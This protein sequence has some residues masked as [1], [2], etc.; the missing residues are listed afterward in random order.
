MPKVHPIDDEFADLLDSDLSDEDEAWGAL[1]SKRAKT[2][3]TYVEE[4]KKLPNKKAIK[5]AL[6]K[7]TGSDLP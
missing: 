3:G 7:S 4:P 2:H 1:T 5:D 6:S